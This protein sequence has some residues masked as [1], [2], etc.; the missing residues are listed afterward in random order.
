MKLVKSGRIIK[1]TFTLNTDSN[2][3]E[4]VLEVKKNDDGTVT[5]VTERVE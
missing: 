3:Q 2:K 5:I 4:Q 1:E